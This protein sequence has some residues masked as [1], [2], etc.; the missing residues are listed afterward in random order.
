[1]ENLDCEL[2]VIENKR[3]KNNEK[4]MYNCYPCLASSIE[5]LTLPCLNVFVTENIEQCNCSN[6]FNFEYTFD[7]I[8]QTNFTQIISVQFEED[9]KKEEEVIEN[10]KHE[11]FVIEEDIEEINN[12]VVRNF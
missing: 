2:V 1:M 5:R 3:R 8:I 10:Y 6:C 4:S 12:E 11:E 9:F 7:E